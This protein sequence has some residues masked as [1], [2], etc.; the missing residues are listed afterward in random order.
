MKIL[1]KSLIVYNTWED[2]C[3]ANQEIKTIEGI[4]MK[5]LRL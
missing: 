3:F 1:P 2:D 4:A 5:L